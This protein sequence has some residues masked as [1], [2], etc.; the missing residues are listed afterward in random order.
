MGAMGLMGWTIVLVVAMQ[1]L[2]VRPLV[3]MLCQRYLIDG[4]MG[5][6]NSLCAAQDA[7]Q[8]ATR[9][10]RLRQYDNNDQQPPAG[11]ASSM[12]H[13]ISHTRSCMKCT[14]AGLQ[15]LERL[16]HVVGPQEEVSREDEE[17]EVDDSMQ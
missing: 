4:P 17:H 11:N 7:S 3:Q 6:H 8:Q 15:G 12:P 14:I 2:P 10:S 1:Q 13:L 5:A 16:T 9:Q